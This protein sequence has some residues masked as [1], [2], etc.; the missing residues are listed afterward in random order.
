MYIIY[1]F[2]ANALGQQRLNYGPNHLGRAVSHARRM[3]SYDGP[4]TRA[5]IRLGSPTGQ[6]LATVYYNGEEE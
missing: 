5:E 3:L 1:F 6:L 4:D 2:T